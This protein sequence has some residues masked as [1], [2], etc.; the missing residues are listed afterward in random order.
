M[1]DK[2]FETGKGDIWAV[3]VTRPGP[4]PK[5]RATFR[6][7]HFVCALVKRGD[8]TS[9]PLA[10]IPDSIVQQAV[11]AYDVKQAAAHAQ[12]VTEIV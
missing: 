7:Q 8:V 10:M 5:V 12:A 11:R 6:E 3:D 9:P 4:P 2:L 1:S